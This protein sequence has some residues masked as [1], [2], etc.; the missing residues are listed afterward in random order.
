MF[1]IVGI[2]SVHRLPGRSSLI[3]DIR[4]KFDT[5]DRP[6]FND[7]TVDVHSIAS[8]LKLYLRELPAPLVPF[9]F[10]E[11][12]MKICTRDMNINPDEALVHLEEVSKPRSSALTCYIQ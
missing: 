7:D 4:E 2:P 10:Y 1:I 6:D 5:G 8:L 12:V 11:Q 3:R 9:F